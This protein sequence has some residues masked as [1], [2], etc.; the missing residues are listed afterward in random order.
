[1]KKLNVRGSKSA[2]VLHTSACSVK[3]KLGGTQYYSKLGP[4]P[5]HVVMHFLDII[6]IVSH[7]LLVC[8]CFMEAITKKSDI[9]TFSTA[10]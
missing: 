1:M 4:Y 10:I 2:C 6:H 5:C 3:Q 8:K 7:T 9:G